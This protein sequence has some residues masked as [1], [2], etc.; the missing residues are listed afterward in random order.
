[1]R[2]RSSPG[3]PR[4]DGS[5]VNPCPCQ[6]IKYLKLSKCFIGAMQWNN[7]QNC[8]KTAG[9]EKCLPGRSIVELTTWWIQPVSEISNCAFLLSLLAFKKGCGR[10]GLHLSSPH[11]L[12][13]NRWAALFNQIGPSGN[14]PRSFTA[15]RT[16]R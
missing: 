15:H 3:L 4:I 16:M 5:S 9:A 1:M 10:S 8:E 6:S 13:P 12:S 14:L 11:Q 2:L 7:E